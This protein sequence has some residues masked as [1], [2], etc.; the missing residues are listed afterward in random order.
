MISLWWEMA[1]RR[2]NMSWSNVWWGSE[3]KARSPITECVGVIVSDQITD[4]VLDNVKD[5]VNNHND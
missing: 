5:Q 1:E 2:R 4:Q 3:G